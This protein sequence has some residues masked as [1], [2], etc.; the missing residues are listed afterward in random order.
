MNKKIKKVELV[1]RKINYLF[2]SID[3]NP[4]KSSNLEMA[5]LKRYAINLY[6]TILE[7]E[8]ADSWGTKETHRLLEDINSPSELDAVISREIETEEV[9]ETP[10]E[11]KPE[12]QEEVTEDLTSILK[13]V[14]ERPEFSQ[15]VEEEP[16]S[17]A[18]TIS[19][20]TE[21]VSEPMVEKAPE[22]VAEEPVKIEFT[23]PKETV[24]HRVIRKQAPIE[25]VSPIPE[26]TKIIEPTVPIKKI[27]SPQPEVV[28]IVEPEID[29]FSMP[30]VKQASAK[31]E[32]STSSV[33]SNL[34]AVD[35]V[36]S[37]ISLSELVP[38]EEV[39]KVK[40][41]LPE[42]EERES[43]I[44]SRTERII[45]PVHETSVEE[46]VSNEIT[47]PVTV[48]EPVV[49][50]EP[51][52]FVDKTFNPEPVETYDPAVTEVI[53]R[54]VIEPEP[55]ISESTVDTN[56]FV[57]PAP[58]P[59]A[60][61]IPEPEPIA[62]SVVTPEP[63]IAS[64]KEE[65]REVI[66]RL[67]QGSNKVFHIDHNQRYGF[68]KELFAGNEQA[69]STTVD[70]LSKCSNVIEAFTYLNL[71]VKLKYN[72]KDDSQYAQ[73]FQRIVKETFLRD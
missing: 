45:P 15:P 21:K 65:K 13:Q 8:E 67:R 26:V 16:Q 7:F 58:I 68:V 31:N 53:T 39:L 17:I 19:E 9:P 64:A 37:T 30:G 70:D 60:N 69:Y 46:V 27:A 2:D 4:L 3:A 50:P 25:A 1:L 63:E 36:K 47:E 28:K 12:V 57:P 35:K 71:N 43:R 5:L 44:L 24:I 6:D 48:V 20:P 34:G 55:I 54:P 72:W 18:E 33:T 38:D 23:E 32:A 51:Q 56:Q 52:S 40:E 42:P 66:D 62:Q 14:Q 10:K 73:E 22:T 29:P 49:E 11:H 59:A 61:P 41:I